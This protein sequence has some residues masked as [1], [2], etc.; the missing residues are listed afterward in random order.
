MTG[1][2]LYPRVRGIQ[3]PPPLDSEVHGI[4]SLTILKWSMALLKPRSIAFQSY[5]CHVHTPSGP[6][7]ADTSL[8]FGVTSQAGCE[9]KVAAFVGHMSVFLQE[10]KWRHQ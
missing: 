1:A 5:V 2:G 4:Q 10:S 8:H 7:A 9:G 6:Q 3:L